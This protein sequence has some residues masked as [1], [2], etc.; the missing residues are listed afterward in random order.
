MTKTLVY[1]KLGWGQVACQHKCVTWIP[2]R[3]FYRML[4]LT[5]IVLTE[6][7]QAGTNNDHN[8]YFILRLKE[9]HV[10]CNH[11]MET[12]QLKQTLPA[13]SAPSIHGLAA[14]WQ[15]K[16]VRRPL[17]ADRNLTLRQLSLF[18]SAVKDKDLGGAGNQASSGLYFA[19]HIAEGS[20]SRSPPWRAGDEG[21]WR[22]SAGRWLGSIRDE[23]GSSFIPC[24]PC[25]M[26][27][28]GPT[29]KT[30]TREKERQTTSQPEKPGSKSC[31]I[32][33]V[34]IGS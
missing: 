20:F 11:W 2:V 23:P 29:D 12:E 10:H 15:R 25:R 6:I 31:N 3:W 5:W 34:I 18:A 24:Q 19:A 30:L 21:L 26:C 28:S 27:P 14:S 8:L 7:H 13:A 22:R 4:P 1:D 32:T 33:R 17:W 9:I 16:T